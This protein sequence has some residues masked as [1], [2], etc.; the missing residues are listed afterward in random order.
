[1]LYHEPCASLMSHDAFFRF[2]KIILLGL[3]FLGIS[4]KHDLTLEQHDSPAC[5]WIRAHSNKRYK[6]FHSDEMIMQ[7]PTNNTVTP[8]NNNR[9]VL[10]MEMKWWVGETC[11][12]SQ[13][14]FQRSLNEVPPHDETDKLF[15]VVEQNVTCFWFST[16]FPLTFC[17]FLKHSET[18]HTL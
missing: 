9:C 7:Q 14:K 10:M 18:S 17:L 6:C 16:S 8:K 13:L 2:T 12:V 5:F 1:M 11:S 15:S 3:N 4:Q